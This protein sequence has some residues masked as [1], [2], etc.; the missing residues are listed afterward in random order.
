MNAC[1]LF[2]HQPGKILSLLAQCPPV[3]RWRSLIGT[4]LQASRVQSLDSPDIGG[5]K[6][7]LDA[8]IDRLVVAGE[9]LLRVARNLGV[10]R[11]RNT[12]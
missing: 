4:P 1:V 10:V 12:V 6:P 9:L 5:G 7:L 8:R 3:Q 2:H 11:E